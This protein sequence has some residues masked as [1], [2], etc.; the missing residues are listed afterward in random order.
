MRCWSMRWIWTCVFLAII[1][2]VINWQ[3]NYMR[4]SIRR[5]VQEL[6]AYLPLLLRS[7]LP[8]PVSRFFCRNPLCC[9]KRK[10]AK[11]TYAD[12]W[13]RLNK[14]IN[15]SRPNYDMSKSFGGA[16]DGFKSDQRRKSF[17]G[18]PF[19]TSNN[20][21]NS[22]QNPARAGGKLTP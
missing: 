19:T 15:N 18:K 17:V 16:R 3:C 5:I 8:S 12:C 20:I 10:F 11:H 13:R 1:R 14:D 7:T 21:T 22:G 2:N 4:N 6:K 9:G